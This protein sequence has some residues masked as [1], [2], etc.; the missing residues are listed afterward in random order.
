VVDRPWSERLIARAI[1]KQI[2][3][4]KCIVLLENTSWAGHESDLL[5][6]TTDLRLI[7]VEVKIS[8][9]DLK[10]DAAKEK[11][12]HRGPITG[13]GAPVEKRAPDGRLLS[14]QRPFLQESTALFWPPK[15]WKHYYAVPAEIWKPEIEETLPSPNSGVLTLM[16]QR[17]EKGAPVVVHCVRR[18]K[19][20]RDCDRISAA[21]ALDIAR[22]ASFRMWE[23]FKELELSKA[24][25]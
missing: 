2:L 11:W 4:D 14:S 12:W 8:R 18:A 17:H 5:G 24:P 1:A 21:D 7:D 19:P 15:V 23:A 16:R 9:A 6:V 10:R 3:H 20:N 22:L 13:L 25:A